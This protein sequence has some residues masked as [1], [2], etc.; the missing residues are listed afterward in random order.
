MN[1]KHTI[2]TALKAIM[3]HKS[4]S[5]LT[6]LGIVIGVASVIVV[7][8][9]GRGAQDLILNQISGLGAETVVL[10]S[11]TGLSDFTNVL[12]SQSLV[13]KDVDELEKKSNVPNLKEI[14]PFVAMSGGIE[15]EGK[16]YNPTLTAGPVEF[17]ADVFEV[18][19]EDGHYFDDTEIDQRKRVA[20]LGSDIKDE[21]FENR[22]A[23]GEDIQIRGKKFKVV[24]VF[25]DVPDA[26]GFPFNEAV[27]IP[28]TSAQDLLGTNHY[29]EVILRADSVENVEK[30]VADITMTM[31][32]SHDLSYGEEND[33]NIQTQENMMDMIENVINILTWFLVAVVTISLIVGGV[34]IM[35]IMLVSV[36]ERTK[37]IGL[38]KALGA[39]RSDIMRQFLFEAITLTSLGGILGVLIGAIISFVASLTISALYAPNWVFSFPISA[40]LIGV[41][42]SATVGLIF[43]VYPAVQAS[44]KSPMEALRYE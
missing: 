17:M 1:L 33:F 13:Q 35:N 39:R 2:K 28:H 34:G 38:R 11:G 36:T 43:G 37:E 14:A 40:A 7:M 5:L 8:S 27:M 23:V 6:I 10:R 26:G 41:G 25:E 16:K 29:L 31:R 20:V 24:A 19:P 32:D 4:R 12:L 30:M 42:M 18:N 3:D 21:L 15:Y 44:K 9:L 22:R